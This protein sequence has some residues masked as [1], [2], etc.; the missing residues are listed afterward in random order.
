MPDWP[1]APRPLPSYEPA[2]GATG[3]ITWGFSVI[4]TQVLTNSLHF[5][6]TN[7]SGVC[8][9][10]GD[11]PATSADMG[12]TNT[13]GEP[14]DDVTAVTHTITVH[15]SDIS[16]ASQTPIQRRVENGETY[17]WTVTIPNTGNSP[18]N[19]LLVTE[20][21]G[22]GW[23]N[24]TSTLGTL[25]AT[26]FT[27]TENP[28]GGGTIVWDIG[29]LAVGATWTAQFWGDAK[30]AAIDYRTTLDLT[31]ACDDGGC[32]QTAQRI[33]HSSPFQDEAKRISHTPVSVGELFSYTISV[34]FFGTI[35][36]TNVILTDTL[37]KLDNTL[38][39]SITDI[40]I[41]NENSGVNTWA[42]SGLGTD[43]V[44]FSP[45]APAVGE[46]QG[47]EWITITLTGVISN[48][49][50]A[51]KDDIFTNTFDLTFVDDTRPYTYSE[52]VE[53]VVREPILSLDKYATPLTQIEAGDIVT[54]NVT[55][56]H[57]GA[58]TA[59]AYDV[60]ITDLIPSDLTL[61]PNSVQTI[62]AASSVVSGCPA[63]HRHLRRLHQPR[64]CDQ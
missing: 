26:A 12:Y 15:K 6:V 18:T 22:V 30:D 48:S 21:L 25:P 23:E 4:D 20:T 7:A 39:F 56:Q 31:T 1:P 46:I 11:L 50:A 34:D 14:F 47:P 51:D 60:V 45:T 64:L 40:A 29:S 19:N 27:V 54:Y 10:S 41:Q 36:Y 5:S 63:H 9:A 62:P 28:S 55:A 13:C 8:A 43:K 33:N 61:V 24:F 52:S 16:T 17:T 35:T 59:I 53:G 2:L 38:V 58:S 37:P 3:T 57:T 49:I 44:V 42:Y 32:T